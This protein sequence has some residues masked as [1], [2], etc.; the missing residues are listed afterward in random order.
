EPTQREV[1]L[2]SLPSFALAAGSLSPMRHQQ[3]AGPADNDDVVL[4]V[5]ERG[6][7]ELSPHGHMPPIGDEDAVT[8]TDAS[9]G[10]AGRSAARV[11]DY[12]FSRNLLLPHVADLDEPVTRP[13]AKDDP[14]LRLLVGYAAMLNDQGEPAAAGLRRAVNAHMH[15][16]AAMLLG[17]RREA[18]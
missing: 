2:R 7:N 18:H 13:I 5:V 6:T 1:L 14:A 11:I 4:V 12:R 3:T 8:A 10:V 9:A 15:E 17:G 16:L